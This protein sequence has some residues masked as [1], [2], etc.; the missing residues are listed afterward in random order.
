MHDTIPH[1]HAQSGPHAHTHDSP[2]AHTEGSTHMHTPE[3]APEN[4]DNLILDIGADTGALVIHAA[5]DRDQAEVE[6]SPV[7]SEQARSHNIVRRRE[8]VSGPVYAA[9]FPALTAGDYVVWRDA[10]T[11]AGLVVVHG[12]RV[13]SFR[14]DYSGL[15]PIIRSIAG[16]P[17]RT[18]RTIKTAARIR[19]TMLSQ[20]V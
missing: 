13:A 5:V 9:V 20:V 4:V 11:P 19:K 3:Q 12:G 8:A 17:V 6:I 10:D 14:L 2:H 15:P 7:G 18:N 16:P 1:D